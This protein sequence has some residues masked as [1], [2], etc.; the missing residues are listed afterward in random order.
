MS[1]RTTE[2]ATDRRAKSNSAR[3]RITAVY[4]DKGV[5]KVDVK[6]LSGEV[7]TGVERFQQSGLTTHPMAGAEVVVSYMGGNRTHPIV[8]AVEDK[9]RRKKNLKA[10]GAALQD[11]S[12]AGVEVVTESDG[13]LVNSNGQPLTMRFDDGTTLTMGGGEVRIKKGDAEVT[14]SDTSLVAKKGLLVQI[15]P[16]RVDLGGTGGARVATEAGLSSKV[17]AIV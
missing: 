16:T 10:G 4:D 9:K 2:T 7:H 1:V 14:I 13:L 3:G 17:F 15:T 12:G 5:Q 6:M 8:T 11:L